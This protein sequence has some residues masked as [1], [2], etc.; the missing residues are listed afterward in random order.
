MSSVPY[1]APFIDS[2][3]L[4]VPDYASIEAYEIA[5]FQSVFGQSVYGGNDSADIQWISI[6][7]LMINDAFNT[8]ELAINARSPLTAVGGDLD[9][10]VKINGIARNGA[11]AS[12]AVLTVTG[13]P[14]TVLTNAV[15]QDINNYLWDLPI[16]L[17]IPNTGTINVTAVCETIGAIAAAPSTITGI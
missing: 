2:A 15:A 12:T 3:G 9:S 14:G 5:Q 11:T 13:T 6:F 1:F 4:H 7:S 10:I 17:T 8:A 16:S